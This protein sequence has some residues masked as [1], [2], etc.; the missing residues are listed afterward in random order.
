MQSVSAA[1]AVSI[2][3]VRQMSG[4]PQKKPEYKS[5]FGGLGIKI[6]LDHEGHFECDSMVKLPQIESCEFADL[7][8]P[9]HKCVPVYEQFP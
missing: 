9:V 5:E 4:L 1:S 8:E 2:T 6:L 3:S 7:F